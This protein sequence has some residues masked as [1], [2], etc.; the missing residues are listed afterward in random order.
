MLSK[1]KVKRK[2]D[3]LKFGP[4]NIPFLLFIPYKFLLLF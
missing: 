3:T 1:D 4:C 2:N